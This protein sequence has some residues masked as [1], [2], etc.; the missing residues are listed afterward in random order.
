MRKS[1]LYTSVVAL[2]LASC[3]SE[4]VVEHY[5][6]V[7]GQ[8]EGAQGKFIKI[9]D[10]TKAGF[11]PDSILIDENGGF[12]FNQKCDEPKDFVLY[13]EPEENI[14]ILPC[15]DEHVAVVARYPNIS[16]N[17]S[18]SGSQE[19]ERLAELLKK[20]NHCN[21]VLDTLDHY[22]MSHQ[23]D[24]NFGDIV[25]RVR[26]LSD[27]VLNADR[28]LHESF[29]RQQPGS[30]ASYV[31]LSSKLG[32]RTNLFNIIPDLDYFI[33]VDTALMNRYDTISITMMLDRY[34]RQA[35]S[36]ELMQ[37]KRG[38][39]IAVGDT[40][41]D[42]ALSNP[43]GDTIRLSKLKAKYVLVNFWGSW[44]RPCRESHQELRKVFRNYRYKGFDIYSIALERSLDDWKN[45]I[46]EDRLIWINHVS[47]LAYMDSKVARQLGVESVPFNVL[48]DANRV[49][50]AKNLTPAQL[51]AKLAELTTV[52]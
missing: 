30:L 16:E 23:L 21:Y 46:R 50:L 2:L 24:R 20:H 25:A 36:S 18:V 45:T 4:P 9:I 42:I 41:P 44:C 5:L 33:M 17:Y 38:G 7:N 6:S 12:A 13:I 3:N 48:V 31:A 28:Q 47:E 34:V 49:V 39:Q 1:I 22:Y 27:S 29:I 52:K 15:P 11:T 37:H 35:Q 8:I 51:D 10:M 14:R 40:I 32:L 26:A 43:Y 19:S